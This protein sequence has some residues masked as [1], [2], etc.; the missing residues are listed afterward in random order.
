MKLNEIIKMVDTLNPG[1]RF[2]N[3][4]KTMWLSEI[5]GKIFD[6][7]GIGERLYR[8]DHMAYRIKPGSVIWW[9]RK[10]PIW[11][12]QFREK[13]FDLLDKKEEA[14]D[15][16]NKDDQ[17]RYEDGLT[18]K[19]LLRRYAENADPLN[20]GCKPGK[21]YTINELRPYEYDR[22]QNTVL[23][24]PNRF[25]DVY[26]QYLLAKMHASDGEIEEYNNAVVMYTAAY[27][28]YS[29]WYIRTHSEQG[30]KGYIF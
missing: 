6:E 15:V 22:D 23:V 28:D 17:E 10:G 4:L 5:D 18:Q 9:W 11:T 20:M 3:P 8:D 12:N 27:Q 2:D 19:L 21:P 16:N 13:I 1:N 7:L 29:S 24:V 26:T 30:P 25:S 14:Q